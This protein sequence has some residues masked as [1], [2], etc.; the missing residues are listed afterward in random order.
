MTNERNGDETHDP[1]A[2]LIRIGVLL[3][4]KGDHNSLA[5]LVQRLNKLVL[6]LELVSCLLSLKAA[7]RFSPALTCKCQP[8]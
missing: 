4:S 8:I 5:T 7:G 3:I 6:E 1:G 2:P